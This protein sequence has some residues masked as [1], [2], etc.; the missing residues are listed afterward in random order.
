MLL[1]FS[2]TMDFKYST[3]SPVSTAETIYDETTLDGKALVPTI[4]LP[5]PDEF[6]DEA[7]NADVKKALVYFKSIFLRGWLS[8]PFTF[9]WHM[10]E[11]GC[12]WL[13]HCESFILF[14]TSFPI[15][16][17]STSFL[18]GIW[19]HVCIHKCQFSFIHPT[20]SFT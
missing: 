14:S 17:R 9:Y 10:R 2:Q 11:G 13:Y 1:I 8:K 3:I 19:L 15:H 6:Q 18:Y 7:I 16:S 20:S 4:H 5:R 12:K